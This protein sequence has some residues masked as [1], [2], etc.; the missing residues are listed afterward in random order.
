MR[1]YVNLLAAAL[2]LGMA[3]VVW[4]GDGGEQAASGVLTAPPKGALPGRQA[5]TST[6]GATGW[7]ITG[8]IEM[9][10]LEDGTWRLDLDLWLRPQ[11]GSPE[12]VTPQPPTATRTPT[13]SPTLTPTNTPL[14]AS[15]TPTQ[16][17]STL[18]PTFTL[19]PAPVKTC[20]IKT[21][22]FAINERSEP[23]T[24]APRIDV[25]PAGSVVTLSRFT[26]GEGYL[27][28]QTAFGWMVVR[29]GGTWWVYGLE[30]TELCD[31]VPGWPE[32][33][34][35]PPAIVAN[36]IGLHMIW[37]TDTRAV[38]N[39]YLT[40]LAA[41]GLC[42]T[43]MKALDLVEYIIPQIKR[44][45]PQTRVIYRTIICG[46]YP[47]WDQS[48]EVAAEQFYNCARGRWLLS[49]ADAYEVINESPAPT[50]WKARFSLRVLELGTR[51][52][53]SLIVPGDG[54]GNPEVADY[55]NEYAKLYAYIL[56]HPSAGHA[57][58]THAYGIDRYLSDSGPWLGFR[59]R[60]FYEAMRGQV[61]D[62]ARVPVYLTEIGS[63][64]A[65][66]ND[67]IM[68]TGLAN[69][70]ARYAVEL[71]RD[72]YVRGAHLFTTG[73]GGGE[74]YAV[75]GCLAAIADALRRAL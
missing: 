52:G 71:R 50:A 29:Q 47:R 61:A 24:T 58:S 12:N 31:Q 64:G 69:D 51:D 16:E 28:G 6:P 42:P 67:P 20:V 21:G 35:P 46:D 10:R 27:W 15:P 54:P 23:R 66:R 22:A 74:W 60:L 39:D 11:D 32:G 8:G 57:I 56:A 19:T 75:D 33:L 59:H 5:V 43:S 41:A 48:P 17:Q 65:F 7:R 72:P 26:Q 62:A 63:Y 73:S 1:R 9:R 49:G 68:C 55:A 37:G 44:I 45:C 38:L 70:M 3:G 18:P 13:P 53:L 30:G 4:A 34:A 2:L 25:I 14:P 36:P 40:P